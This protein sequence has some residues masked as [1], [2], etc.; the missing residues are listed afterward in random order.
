MKPGDSE[1]TP[2]L[3]NFHLQISLDIT[4]SLWI[5]RYRNQIDTIP[6]SLLIRKIM[7][8]MSTINTHRLTIR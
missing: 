4:I 5:P 2:Y 7:S 8:Q 6:R 1:K 3:R